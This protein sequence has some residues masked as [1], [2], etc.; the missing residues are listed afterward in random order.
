MAKVDYKLD[1]I[2][3]VKNLT[4]FGP[5]INKTITLTTDFGGQRGQREM[6]LKAPWHDDT[7]AARNGLNVNVD[8]S[9]T[10]GIGFALHV[11]TFAHAVTYG[12]WLEV[13]NNGKYQIIM[14]TV[15][16]T[17]KEVMKALSQMFSK[18]DMPPEFNVTV[19]L[20]G[21]G[22]QGTSQGAT[23]KGE[24]TART[25]KRTAKGGSTKSTNR[26]KRT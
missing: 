1:D 12:I 19:D 10:S 18:L 9:G 23:V 21:I 14:P 8:H 6:K 13:A 17:G 2:Q 5:K 7:G 15:L 11:L 20:P 3:L 25:A 24:K 4:E 22:R 26:T 16:A